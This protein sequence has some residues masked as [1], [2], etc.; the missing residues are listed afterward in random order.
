MASTAYNLL[1]KINEKN[2]IF[3][4]YNKITKFSKL[5]KEKNLR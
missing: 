5:K 2:K 3:I 4:K 1:K